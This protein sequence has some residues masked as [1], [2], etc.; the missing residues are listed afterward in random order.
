MK[1]HFKSLLVGLFFV[2]NF[3]TASNG[4][5]N[6]R[7]LINDWPQGAK[8]VNG[9]KSKRENRSS[10]SS[11]L[12]KSRVSNVESRIG[13]LWDSFK[14]EKTESCGRSLSFALEALFQKWK[15]YSSTTFVCKITCKEALDSIDV[16]AAKLDSLENSLQRC[17]SNNKKHFWYGENIPGIE[18]QV[19]Y[20]FSYESNPLESGLLI[21]SEVST[22]NNVFGNISG[23]YK[24][25]SSWHQG[26]LSAGI[27][28]EPENENEFAWKHSQSHFYSFSRDAAIKVGGEYS[29]SYDWIPDVAGTERVQKYTSGLSADISTRIFGNKIEE[30][31]TWGKNVW[32]PNLWGLT[33]LTSGTELYLEDTTSSKAWL[34]VDVS[35][36]QFEENLSIADLWTWGLSYNLSVKLVNN[37]K[38]RIKLGFQDER[39]SQTGSKFWPDFNMEFS[40]KAIAYP[41]IHNHLVFSVFP[42]VTPWSISALEMTGSYKIS[43][44]HINWNFPLGMSLKKQ[45]HKGAPGGARDDR[46]LLIG[47]AMEYK[48][49]KVYTAHLKIESERRWIS[50]SVV[51]NIPFAKTSFQN[52]SVVGGVKYDF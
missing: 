44:R 26:I 18:S 36:N 35:K 27:R 40:S 37:G 19:G 29:N 1:Y 10:F 23:T 30:H 15:K 6:I 13:D 45:M 43:Y 20:S 8:A 9:K 21:P 51:S 38:I 22:A 25:E 28:L 47:A 41:K 7:H 49:Q 52:F 2:S 31:I 16:V 46:I 11:V 33:K 32:R 5:E 34:R 24:T 48:H 42:I 39:N 17:L 3:S 12:L 4:S 14:N 50:D